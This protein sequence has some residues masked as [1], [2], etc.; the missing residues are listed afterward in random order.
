M[1]LIRWNPERDLAKPSEDFD[2]FL[3]GFWNSE[4]SYLTNFNPS[5][6]IEENDDQFIF[7]A[8]LPGIDKKNV[9][10]S[11]KDN[12]LTLSGEKQQKNE[13]KKL[14]FHR[15]ESSYGKFQRCFKLPENIK[16]DDV[17]AD[18][19]DGILNITV[20]KTEKAKPREI[21]IA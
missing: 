17:T 8:E 11:I 10:I 6:D 12:I 13:K 16:Q 1:S 5:V 7:H 15:I 14:N 18:F 9:N 4:D 3:K 2:N 21:K 20:P 19:K